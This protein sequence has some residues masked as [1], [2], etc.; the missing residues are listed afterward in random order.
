[1]NKHG[2]GATKRA[3]IN[4]LAASYL[5]RSPGLYKVLDALRI[6]REFAR[7]TMAANDA[8]PKYAKVAWLPNDK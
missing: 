4:Q 7:D 8:F 1:M 3:L 2:G 5:N 6:Y